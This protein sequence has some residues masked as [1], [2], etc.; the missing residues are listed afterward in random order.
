MVE[1]QH[2]WAICMSNMYEQYVWTIC[3]VYLYVRLVASK[4]YW[5]RGRSSG[6][7]PRYLSWCYWSLHVLPSLVLGENDYTDT[8]HPGP[9]AAVSHLHSLWRLWSVTCI[10]IYFCSRWVALWLTFVVGAW[11]WHWHLY[12]VN[13]T[14]IHFS[15]QSFIRDSNR[16]ERL[17]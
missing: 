5:G 17:W 1:E 10:A 8:S 6:C 16:A 2:T 7:W 14:G 11:Y 9:T 3:I 12:S 15:R 4:L 13:W